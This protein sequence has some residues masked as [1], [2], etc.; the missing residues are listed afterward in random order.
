MMMVSKIDFQTDRQSFSDGAE[1]PKGGLEINI[2]LNK[3]NALSNTKYKLI[4]NAL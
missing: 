2:Q 3:Q 1:E 4:L